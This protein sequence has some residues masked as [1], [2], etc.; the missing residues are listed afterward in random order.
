MIYPYATY[1]SETGVLRTQ[2][3]IIGTAEIKCLEPIVRIQLGEGMI[4]N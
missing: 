4:G 3:D 2:S 1:F